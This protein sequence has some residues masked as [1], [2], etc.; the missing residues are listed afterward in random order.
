MKRDS[1]NLQNSSGRKLIGFG[2]VVVLHL[3]LL[4]AIQSGLT[5]SVLQKMPNVVQAIL[6][7]E[8]KQEAPQPPPSPVL[9]ASP[10]PK[11]Q[12]APPPPA[13]TPPAYVPPAEVPT[14]AAPAAN[15]L[16][17]VSA[18]PPPAPAMAPAPAVASAPSKPA[19][20]AR[21]AAG[22]STAHCEKPEYPVASRRL[23]EEGTVS[24]RFL[25][26]VDGRVIQ[27]EIEK[28]SRF[29]RLD[30]AARAGLSKCQFRPATVDGKPEQAWARI[31]Y[32]WRLE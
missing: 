23:E 18:T 24:L 32:T 3:L 19:P 31:Q 5:R 25:V 9:P 4:W 28:S 10:P 13:P 30:E 6:L 11:P 16:A 27:S 12:A 2:A 14:T 20:P 7:E 15:A 29:K 22:V 17:A 1:T 26:A 21:T 8:R